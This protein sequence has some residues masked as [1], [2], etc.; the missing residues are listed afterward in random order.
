MV[1]VIL[2]ILVLA[3]RPRLD[4]FYD[5]KLSGAG[6]KVI[7][8]IRYAQ[9]LSI[10]RHQDYELVFDVINESY[11]LRR[12]S[13]QQLAKDT[14]TRGDLTVNFTTDNEYKG[15]DIYDVDFNASPVLRFNWEGVPQDAGGV[16][17]TSSGTIELS[18]HGK[19]LT[20]NV[21]PQTGRVT[22]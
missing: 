18:Y 16:S 6:K 9:N 20:I 14:F 19:S 17:L 10:S 2:G 22:W 11:L 13:D 5:L 4:I 15:I 1:I 21:S 8:D 7:S 3:S 12:T